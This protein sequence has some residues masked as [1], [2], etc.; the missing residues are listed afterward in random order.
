MGL[1]G[2]NCGNCPD[3]KDKKCLGGA[4]DC[5][6]MRC[7]RNLGKCMITHYCTETESVLDRK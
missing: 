6:C 1:K 7:P 3:F 4:D 2:D 5:M